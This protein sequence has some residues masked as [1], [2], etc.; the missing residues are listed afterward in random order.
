[1]HVLKEKLKHRGSPDST[2][3]RP[4]A[5]TRKSTIFACRAG[6]A[7]GRVGEK[8]TEIGIGQGRMP[9]R[10]GGIIHGRVG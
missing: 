1:M 5:S 7:D 3:R 2:L 8:K 4:E 9:W 10:A 6:K